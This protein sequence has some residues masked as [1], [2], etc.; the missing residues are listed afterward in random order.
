M[1]QFK[2][3]T[4]KETDR[5]LSYDF[6]SMKEKP[7]LQIDPNLFIPFSFDYIIDKFTMGILDN[8]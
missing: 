6:L 1:S 3:K 2:T 7:F 5:E 4:G 8:I